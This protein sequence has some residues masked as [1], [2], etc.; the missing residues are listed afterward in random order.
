MDRR[1]P[2]VEREG[3]P[4]APQAG[5][6]TGVGPG[7]NSDAVEKVSC[8]YLLAVNTFGGLVQSNSSIQLSGNIFDRSIRRGA[9]EAP[10]DRAGAVNYQQVGVIGAVESSNLL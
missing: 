9:V 3:R 6:A 4:A 8:G 1:D 7:M 10:L 2:H 5:A